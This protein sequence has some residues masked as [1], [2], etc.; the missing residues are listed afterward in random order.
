MSRHRTQKWVKG[1]AWFLLGVVSQM[2]LILPTPTPVK[3]QT[4]GGS[5]AAIVTP[6]T[7]EE[8][9]Y[10]RSAWTYFVDNFQPITGFVNAAGGYPSGTLWDIG[11]YLTALNAARWLNLIDQ[12]EFDSKLN[13]F[14]TSLSKIRLFEDKLPNKVYNTATGEMSNYVNEPIDRG[15]GWSALDIGRLLAAFHI[16]RTCHPQYNDWIQGILNN[17]QLTSAIQDRM[18]YGATVLTNNDT[19]LVQEGRLGY[20]EYAAQGF[21]LWGFNAPKALDLEPFNFA[22]IYELDIP[23]DTRS[24]QRTNANNYVVSESYILD[25]IEFGLQGNLA[26]YA[27]RVF[28]VQKRRYEDTGLLTA[29]S[30]DNINKAPYFLYNTVYA[31]GEKWA[32]ITDTNELHPELRTLSTKAAF[33]WHYVYPQSEY[34]QLVFDKVKDLTNSGRGYFAGV[35]E[36]G[37]NDSQPPLNDILTGNTNGLILEILYYKAR[38]NLSLIGGIPAPTLSATASAAPATHDPASP[39]PASPQTVAVAAIPPVGD[40]QRSSCPAIAH[41]LAI[42]DR[43]YAETAWKYFEA[44]YHPTGLVDDR[45]DMNGVTL[46]GLGDYLAALHAAENLEV[47][48]PQVFDQR[49]RQLLGAVETLPLFAGELPNRSYNTL[50][51]EPID[52]GGSVT[53]EGTGWSGLDIGRM[54]AALH[55]LKTCHSEYTDAVDH[56]TLNWSYLRVVRDGYLGNAT[57]AEDDQGRSRIRVRSSNLLGYEEYAARAFQLWGFDVSHSAISAPYKT[58][59]IEG[60]PIPIQRQDEPDNSSGSQNTVATPFILY[61]L[62]FG[63]DPQMRSSIEAIFRAEAT[64][65]ANTGTYSASGTS[66]IDQAPYVVHSTIVSNGQPWAVVSDAGEPVNKGRIVSTAIAFAYH[67]LFPDDPYSQALWQATIDLYNPVLGYYEG[68]YET[69]GQK[70][71]GFTGGTNSLILQALLN[72]AIDHQ[73]LIQPLPT[74]DSPWWNTIREGDSGQGLPRTVEIPIQMVSDQTGSYWVVSD[75]QTSRLPAAIDRPPSSQQ[76]QQQA[77][78][79]TRQQ[80]RLIPPRL[81]SPT[82]PTPAA[83]VATPSPLPTLP[84]NASSPSSASQPLS[85]DD[86]I[87]AARAW[88]YFENNWNPATGMVN[89]VDKLPWATL[90]DQGSA[91]LGIHAGRQLGLLSPDRFSQ[92]MDRLFTTLETMPLPTHKLPNKAYST[93]TGEMQTLDNQ[94]DPNGASGWSALDISRYLLS[95]RVLQVQYPEYHDRIDRIV[96]K[97]DLT[98][99]VQEGW[100]YGGISDRTGQIQKLQEGRLGYEQYAANALK[101]W[102]IE[103]NSALNN[104]PTQRIDVDG[105]SLQVDQR[106][107]RNSGASNY[108]TSD[109]YTLWGIEIG[110][111]D[112]GKQQADH[113]LAVQAN[114]ASQTGILTAVNEDSLDRP[115]YFLYYCIYV[116]GQPWSAVSVTGQSYPELRF[117]STKAAFA[118]AALYPQSAYAQEVRASVQNLADLNRGYLSGRYEDEALGPNRSI[119]V[120]ANAIILES[121]LYRV[122]SYAPLI[123]VS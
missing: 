70:T 33:G 80:T 89:A 84:S 76:I 116:D 61:G 18:L 16:L 21:Q 8:D 10:A 64:R 14:L 37:L 38:G 100:L 24:Y 36:S 87:A 69:N 82:L 51:L 12:P 11:N 106:Q 3:A 118:W 49:V 17:W 97:Y 32:V 92:W 111:T 103:A 46:W 102:N 117:I 30:E 79:R 1:I 104:P 99:L 15:I 47:I 40:P 71:V 26:E 115:P 53:P 59:E 52:Y 67:T 35:Y 29:V 5:C 93:E 2:M 120:N 119:D 19:L 58:Q 110:W 44:N 48:T 85:E 114:R 22:K 86:R 83:T 39:T 65:Y 122:H 25:A 73:P 66:L 81:P 23:Y 95:L 63:F 77:P 75:Q 20:E 74:M 45:S 108:L 41:P 90:W 91:I 31:N 62:E 27:S 109:P 98:Q 54:L 113:L 101:L 55:T 105:I 107:R 34:G 78:Q 68:F 4:S 50:T 43:R 28:E 7:S 42:P 123:L 57:L 9:A 94:P 13:L 60:Y 56:L 112:A 121:L 72:K 6:L 88:T 96:A